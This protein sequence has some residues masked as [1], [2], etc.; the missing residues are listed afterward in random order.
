MPD[1][2]LI[3]FIWEWFIPLKRQ[4]KPSLAVKC[5]ANAACLELKSIFLVSLGRFYEELGTY[6]GRVHGSLL[7]KRPGSSC[8]R[9]CGWEWMWWKR[10]FIQ[11]IICEHALPWHNEMISLCLRVT[12]PR[13]HSSVRV[14]YCIKVLVHRS[15]W[16]NCYSD[17][18]EWSFFQGQSNLCKKFICLKTGNKRNIK[19]KVRYNVTKKKSFWMFQIWDHKKYANL[20][21]AILALQL[22][23]FICKIC[24][25]QKEDIILLKIHLKERGKT[26]RLLRV[27]ATSFML[28][29]FAECVPYWLIDFIYLSSGKIRQYDSGRYDTCKIEWYIIC[30]SS[31]L[32]F[33]TG[34]VNKLTFGRV[35]D[36]VKLTIVWRHTS[37]QTGMSQ[38]CFQVGSERSSPETSRL[39]A[40]Q[41]M[42]LWIQSGERQDSDET[43]SAGRQRIFCLKMSMVIPCRVTIII[44]H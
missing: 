2:F 12:D 4:G 1:C 11:T 38:Q 25:F 36:V 15:A 32:E 34:N 20:K 18:T 16:A 8:T 24:P 30:P 29:K 23:S 37:N 5:L 26:D 3:E 22:I 35:A 14:W 13:K 40:D 41:G 17:E 6:G 21:L 42:G 33:N 28:I 31:K 43:T 10:V 9:S 39:L 19:V 44:Q 7:A 27:F